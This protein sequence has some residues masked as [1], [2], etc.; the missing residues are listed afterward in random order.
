MVEEEEKEE[1]EKEEEEK[2]EKEEEEKEEEEQEQER[3]EAHTFEEDGEWGGITD[4][5]PSP[6]ID[7][8][9]REEL[10][11]EY[12]DLEHSVAQLAV[13]EHQQLADDSC[14]QQTPT[15]D[16]QSIH[17]D[18]E[19]PNYATCALPDMYDILLEFRAGAKDKGSNRK[20]AALP[21]VPFKIQP[22]VEMYNLFIGR[23]VG[24]AASLLGYTFPEDARPYLA[25][26]KATPQRDF[27]ELTHLNFLQMFE[28][29]WRKE[30]KKKRDPY[31]TG[32]VMRIFTFLEKKARPT[33]TNSND[34]IHRITARRLAEVNEVV[35]EAIQQNVI[36]RVGHFTRNNLN[37]HFAS[38]GTVPA[39]EDIAIPSSNT[40][41]QSRHLD[42]EREAFDTMNEDEMR[43]YQAETRPI[44]ITGVLHLNISDLRKAL[45]LPH[46]DL[47]GMHTFDFSEVN[48]PAEDVED[49]DHASD[50]D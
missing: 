33:A 30:A 42:Q 3:L 13:L 44:R 23:V 17:S 38:R 14:L 24:L 18:D 28:R 10:D 47:N 45:N 15:P 39:V 11:A 22:R 29:V 1:E 25:P 40:F 20:T 35:G 7:P 8:A 50:S 26:T 2:E 34:V 31:G 48:N 32:I 16:S 12:A 27:T 21:A 49:V 19:E 9:L 41:R 6:D 43:E 36:P 5:T 46:F 4:R 37:Q